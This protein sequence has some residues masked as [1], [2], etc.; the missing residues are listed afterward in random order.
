[1]PVA[2]DVDL[3]SG[4]RLR[5]EAHDVCGSP[6]KRMSAQQLRDKVLDCLDFGR[7][8]VNADDLIGAVHGLRDGKPFASVL[9]LIA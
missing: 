7:S 3:A 4:K 6:A 2:F 8:P 9:Q 5:I 1:M